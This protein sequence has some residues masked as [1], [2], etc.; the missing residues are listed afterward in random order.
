VESDQAW[1]TLDQV[2]RWIRFAEIKA[3]VLLAAGAVIAGV[4]LIP[5]VPDGGVKA[6]AARGVLWDAGILAVAVASTLSLVA[7]LAGRRAGRTARA[8]VL[9]PHHIARRARD[10]YLVVLAQTVADPQAV[11]R[12]VADQ[13]WT[14]SILARRNLGLLTA[15]TWLLAVALACGAVT[16]FVDRLAQ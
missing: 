4:L 9:H 12:E 15:A 7:L 11:L 8:S 2:N 10:E 5:A 6:T 1:F 3:L 16:V 13:I 14:G